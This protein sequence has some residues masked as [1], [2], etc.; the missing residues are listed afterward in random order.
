MLHY[1]QKQPLPDFANLETSTMICLP[2]PQLTFFHFGNKNPL[3]NISV[4]M[5]TK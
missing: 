4:E 5:E 3:N 1:I 2:S